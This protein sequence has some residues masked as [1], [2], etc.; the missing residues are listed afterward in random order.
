MIQLEEKSG[1][2]CR[3]SASDGQN[4][5]KSGVERVPAAEVRRRCCSGSSKCTEER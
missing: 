4:E 3:G 2:E 5:R 1:L